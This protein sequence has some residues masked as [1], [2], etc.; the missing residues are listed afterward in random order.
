M[1]N[2]QETILFI[3]VATMLQIF[4]FKQHQNDTQKF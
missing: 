1:L 4:I 2:Y 3:K